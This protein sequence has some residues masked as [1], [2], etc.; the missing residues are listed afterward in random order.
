[1]GLCRWWV[2]VGCR[3]R[4]AEA[5]DWKGLPAMTAVEE[6]DVD[7]GVELADVIWQLRHEL[8][9]AMWA[10]EHTDLRFEAGPI[11]LELTVA[12]EKATQPGVKAR[13]LVMDAELGGRRATTVTQRIHLTLH[14]RRADA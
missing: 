9:R 12:V 2:G 6:P 10:G 5:I 1:M 14:P 3:G 13:L 11:E 7:D 4:G 8:S